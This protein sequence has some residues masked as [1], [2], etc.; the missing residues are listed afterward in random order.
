VWYDLDEETTMR[1]QLLSDWVA[2]HDLAPIPAGCI[3]EGDPPRYFGRE[4]PTP[5]PIEAAALDDAAAERMRFW[6]G[7]DDPAWHEHG[8]QRYRLRYGP[9]VTTTPPPQPRPRQAGDRVAKWVLREPWPVGQWCIPTD[10]VL[11]AVV[12]PDG[13]VVANSLV[14]CGAILPTPLPLCAAS[15]NEPALRLML[16]HDWHGG[17]RHLL[18][19]ERG[20]R[21]VEQV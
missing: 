4:L 18:H 19:F 1:W 3:L 2:F 15:L 11:E 5:M 21:V 14:W 16:R 9:G 17:R 7:P 20:L 10:T 13:E 8:D 12:G 6:Y